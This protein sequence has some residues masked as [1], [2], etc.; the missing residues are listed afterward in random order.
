MIIEIKFQLRFNFCNN[1]IQK[2]F[3]VSGG[4]NEDQGNRM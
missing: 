1:P 3:K 4:T 2:S